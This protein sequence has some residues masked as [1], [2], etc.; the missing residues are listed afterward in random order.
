MA[1]DGQITGLSTD[2]ELRRRAV[3][4]LRARAGFRN[5]LSVYLMINTFV[6]VL[7]V[8]TGGGFFWPVFLIVLWGIGLIG[9]AWDVF[10][11]DPLAEERIR[12]EVERLRH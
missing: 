3:E 7:W 11:P 6:V 10:R 4:R 8:V 5:H 12:R 2:E 1:G 9:N